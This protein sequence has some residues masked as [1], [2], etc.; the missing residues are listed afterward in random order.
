MRKKKNSIALILTIARLLNESYCKQGCPIDCRRFIQ[1]L[2]T[3]G[4]AL[5]YFSR[6]M[7]MKIRHTVHPDSAYCWWPFLFLVVHALKNMFSCLCRHWAWNLFSRSCN[8]KSTVNPWVQLRCT[9]ESSCQDL[10]LIRLNLKRK[11]WAK[12]WLLI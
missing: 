8:A 9:K 11:H 7:S 1:Y 12:L 5:S 3:V 2:V 4:P 10:F 6:S